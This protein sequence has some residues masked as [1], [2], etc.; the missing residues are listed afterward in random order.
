A[1][2]MVGGLTLGLAGTTYYDNVMSLFT[3]SG[4]AIVVT[5]R[6]AMATG[7][8][9]RGTMIAL[10]AGL[11]TGLAVGLKLPQGIFAIGFAAS[12]AAVRGDWKHRTTRLLAGG[13]GGIVSV[14][15]MSGY[16]W[17][18]MYHVTGNPLFPYFN[19]YFHSP[20]ALTA[21]Y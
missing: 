17:L 9:L 5:N 15:L 20:L 13:L 8:L 6:E 19:Q 16:W 10:I 12:L 18:L 21:S 3:L 14:A 4:L 7:T 11:V 2:C 1:L